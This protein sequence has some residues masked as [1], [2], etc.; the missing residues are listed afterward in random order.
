MRTRKIIQRVSVGLVLGGEAIGAILIHESKSL[1][2]T[3]PIVIVGIV[4]T[5]WLLDTGLDTGVKHWNWAANLIGVRTG[6][7]VKIHGYWNSA[8]RDRH[9]TALHEAARCG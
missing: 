3:A 9:G 8:I 5:V 7:K 2:V 4:A 6:S 1:A